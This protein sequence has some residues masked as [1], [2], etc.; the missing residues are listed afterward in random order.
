MIECE[1]ASSMLKKLIQTVQSVIQVPVIKIQYPVPGIRNLC[2][3]IQN[4][5]VSWTLLYGAI[6]K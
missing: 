3:R 2:R 6:V 5:R 4:P 1:S